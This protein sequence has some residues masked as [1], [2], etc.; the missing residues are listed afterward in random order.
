M[1]AYLTLVWIILALVTTPTQ[2]GSRLERIQRRGTLVCGVEPTVPGFAD[3][4]A[5][6]RYR[7]L[8]VDICRALSAAIFGT[9]DKVKYVPVLT[10]AE[11]LRTDD[12]DI[13]SRRL[14]WELRREAPLGL[15]FGPITFYD[16]QGFLVSKKLGITNPRQLAGVPMCVAGGT[17]FEFNAGAYFEAQSLEIRKVLL[18]SHTRFDEIAEA[19]TTGRCRAYTADVSELGGIR[20]KLPHPGDF[21]ILTAQI[22][23]EPLAPLVRQDDPQ[24]FTILRWTIFALVNAEE[25]GISSA[26]VDDMRKSTIV[27][28]Q[29]LLGVVAGNGKALGLSEEWAYHAIKALGNYGEMFERN[30]GRDSAIKL[31]RG[32]NRLWTNGGLMY[33]PP[34]R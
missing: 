25:L 28:V 26:N 1:T 31:D 23:R 21:D 33:A 4:D 11:F 16:G 10:V 18:E 22:S 32:L 24:F 14:T 6:G 9:P 2:A 8:D 20:S 13:V 12:I 5:Q 27:D 17:V 29:R 15:L 3:V 34:L 19:L 30:V 7:G